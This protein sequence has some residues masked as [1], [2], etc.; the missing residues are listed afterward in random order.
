MRRNKKNTEKKEGRELHS[1][2]FA[3]LIKFFLI[4]SSA[5]QERKNFSQWD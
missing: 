5:L 4:L 2:S 3:F 1:V